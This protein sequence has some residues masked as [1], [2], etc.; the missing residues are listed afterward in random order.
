MKRATRAA[1][2]YRDDPDVPPVERVKVLIL[3]GYGTFGGRLARLLCD[4][5]RLTLVIAGRSKAKAEAFCA[6]LSRGA[7]VEAAG[8]DRDRDIGTRITEIAPDVVVDASGPFQAYGSDPYR[9]V[10]ATLAAGAGY[11]DLADGK[12]FVRAIAQ[13]DDAARNAGRFV[14]TGVSSFPVL[15]AAVVHDLAQGLARVDSIAAGI[16]PSPYAGVGENV[17]R[18]IAGYAGQPVRLRRDGRFVTAYPFTETRR[19]TIAPPGRVPLDS[20]EFSLVD[21]PDLEVLADLWPSVQSVWVGAGPVPAVL[22]RLLRWLAYAVRRRW[23]GTLTP[24]APL[25]YRAINDLRWGEHRGG[26]F[27]EIEGERADGGFAKLSWHLLAEGDNGAL[28]PS[29]AAEAI[30]RSL[31]DGRTPAP[32]ARAATNELLLSDYER[33]FARRT[34]YCGERRETPAA[35]EPLYRRILGDAWNQLPQSL[36]NMH[37]SAA[38]SRAEG[39]ATIRRG[40]TWIARLVAAIFGFPAEAEDIELQVAFDRADGVETWRRRFGTQPLKSIQYA[41]RGRFARLLCERFGPFVFGMALV[42]EQGRLGYVLR[43]WSFLGVPLPRA[44]APR[45]ESFEYE[46]AG[47]FHFSVEIALPLAGRIVNYSGRF[48]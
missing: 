19:Y 34:I 15:T 28:I 20:L 12:D 23:V 9:V 27:V 21:V 8:I 38:S 26:M 33:A 2:S 3:G 1:S 10:R 13:F 6:Q 14:L 40:K 39:R 31:L 29:M 5:A 45:G 22:H 47:R 43:R 48:P 36:R 4:D 16:A 17:V 18:A 11:I 46:A 41:G 42:V 30:I 7:G 44:L 24:I 25:M 35:D 37:G 32:G